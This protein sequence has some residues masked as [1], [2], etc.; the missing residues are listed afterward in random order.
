ME[1]K[2]NYHQTNCIRNGTDRE[3][4]FLFLLWTTFYTQA[5]GAT[6]L[7]K[8]FLTTFNIKDKRHVIGL[9]TTIVIMTLTM[10]FAIKWRK[11]KERSQNKE[12]KWYVENLEYDFSARIDTAF[13]LKQHYGFGQVYCTPV[14]IKK[15]NY[16]KED[17][18]K[19]YLTQHDRLRFIWRDKRGQINFIVIS[20]A[21]GINGDSVYINSND[22]KIVVFKNGTKTGEMRI[23]SGL[24]G[25]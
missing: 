11:E 5:L 23:S 18:L 25:Y 2:N 12:K 9:I 17:S 1:V 7:K 8:I 21:L 10:V 24:E 14:S 15:F 20:G 4:F 19:N 6:P 16:Y 3:D 22:D 13:I